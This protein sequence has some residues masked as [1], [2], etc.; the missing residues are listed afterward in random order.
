MIRNAEEYKCLGTANHG[1]R[2]GKQTTDALMEKMMIY[3]HARLTRTSVVTVDNDAKSC[4]DRII[5]TLAMTA[6]MA[7][8]LPKAAAAMHNKTMQEMK[9]TI[10]TRHGLSAPYASIANEDDDDLEGS[11]QGSGA[12]PAI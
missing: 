11:G 4:Y 2:P 12:S 8:G 10:K 6:C 1:S 9:H 3:E 5:R 7:A